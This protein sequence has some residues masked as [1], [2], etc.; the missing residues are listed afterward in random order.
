MIA[1]SLR[2]HP[3]ARRRWPTRSRPPAARAKRPA[4]AHPATKTLTDKSVARI[5]ESVGTIATGDDGK[6]DTAKIVETVGTA[7]TA[8]VALLAE[9]G[10]GT[11]KVTGIGA[12]KTAETTVDLVEAF[13]QLGLGK[14]AAKIAAAGR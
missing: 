6:P 3:P 13:G 9:Y 5:I 4:S 7:V 12:L 14:N 11:G 10:I 1:S 2:P 8:E